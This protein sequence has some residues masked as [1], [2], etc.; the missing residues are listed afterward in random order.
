M[1]HFAV[2]C[3]LRPQAIIYDFR[4]GKIS[5]IR[6]FFDHGEALRAAGLSE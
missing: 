6:T 4:G 1:C 2:L 5:R 3:A